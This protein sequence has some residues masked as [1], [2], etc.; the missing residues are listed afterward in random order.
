M[1]LVDRWGVHAPLSAVPVAVF[2][3]PTLEGIPH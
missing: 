1:Q 3:F 2:L